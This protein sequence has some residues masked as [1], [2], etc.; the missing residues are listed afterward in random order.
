M[1]TSS[2]DDPFA[3]RDEPVGIV[4]MPRLALI[5]RGLKLRLAVP[6]AVEALADLL[7]PGTACKQGLRR[8]TDTERKHVERQPTGIATHQRLEIMPAVGALH[9]QDHR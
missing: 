1:T 7:D 6:D 9:L 8:S 5:Q 4:A 2:N 3:Y